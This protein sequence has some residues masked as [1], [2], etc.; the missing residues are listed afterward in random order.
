VGKRKKYTPGTFCWAELATSDAEAAKSF[1]GALFGWEP[2]D[3]PTG[4]GGVYTMLRKDGNEVCALY[5]LSSDQGDG[6]M[7]PS[8]FSYISVEDVDA[9]VARARELGAGVRDAFDV[10]ESGRM[11][12]IED[13]TGARV[14]AWQPKANIGAT[15]VNEPGAL[16]WNEL[17]VEDTQKGLE[18]YG[19]LLDWSFR[20]IDMGDGRTYWIINNSEHWRN[21]GVRKLM[22]EEKSPP[23]WLVYFA[24]ESCDDTVLQARELGADVPMPPTDLPAG[25]IAMVSDPQGAGFALFEGELDD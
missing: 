16:C 11:A 13:T 8:W 23:H 21:G 1:Y 20:P 3:A 4:E 19:K 7:P 24:V 2:T 25:R 22:P 5:Q 18:F 9:T 12:I 6:G 17:A 10:M 14:G 15:R